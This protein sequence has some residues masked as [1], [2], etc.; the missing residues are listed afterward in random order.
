MK[1]QIATLSILTAMACAPAAWSQGGTRLICSFETPAEIRRIKT[2][3]SR[4]TRVEQH[5]T[6]GRYAAWVDF[7]VAEQPGIELRLEAGDLRPFGSLALDVTNPSDEPLTFTMEVEDASGART[8]AR[9]ALP[10]GPGTSASFALTL[11]S[12]PPLQMGMRG[13]A[14]LPGFRLLSEDHHVVDTAHI[15]AIRLYLIKPGKPCSMMVDN[16]RLAPGISYDRIVDAYGQFAKGEW[17]GKLTSLSQ[18]RSRRSEE[19]AGLKLH[20]TLADRDEFGAWASGPTLEA[21]G[22]F[23]AA[24]HEGKWWLVAPNGH[25]F[26]SIGLD[27][28]TAR[29][30]GTIVEGRENMF[31]WLP[32]AGDPLAAFFEM[33]RTTTPV[34]LRD[35]RFYSGKAFNFYAANLQRKYGDEWKRKWQET[36][37][38]RLRAW[39]VNTIG[40]WS[41]PALYGNG[42]VAYTVTLGVRGT[43]GEVSSGSDYWGRM[44]DVFDPRFAQRWTTV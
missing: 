25:L 44:R 39:G 28:V 29:E 3:G 33:S 9:T 14:A 15:A 41:D 43:V 18:V 2:T 20:P 32:V 40:N 36:A 12:P 21:T 6:E 34:G 38:A 31:E 35:I 10:L 13:E 24:K 8:V 19:E 7:E 4:I 27:C 42:R 1:V 26:F 37:L 5:A 22:F 17:P 16:F 23:R 11:N 30:G